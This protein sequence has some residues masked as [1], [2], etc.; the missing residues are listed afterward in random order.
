MPDFLFMKNQNDPNLIEEKTERL[1]DDYRSHHKE[2]DKSDEDIIRLH[3]E[4]N[5]DAC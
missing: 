5:N 2:K 4:L 3:T 1:H